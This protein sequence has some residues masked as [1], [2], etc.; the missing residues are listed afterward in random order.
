VSHLNIKVLLVKFK[1]LDSEY[2]FQIMFIKMIITVQIIHLTFSM[3]KNCM[4]LDVVK[5][6]AKICCLLL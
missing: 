3:S 1:T 6:E 4:S 2:F 5:K